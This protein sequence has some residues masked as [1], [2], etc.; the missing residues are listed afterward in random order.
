MVYFGSKSTLNYL[1]YSASKGQY[2][3]QDCQILKRSACRWT[4]NANHR[5][6]FK[7]LLYTLPILLS[8]MSN[9]MQQP[10]LPKLFENLTDN[11][12]P[13][14]NVARTLSDI[15]NVS[16]ES[17]YRRL[18]GETSFDLRELL[19]LRKEFGISIDGLID[20]DEIISIR[21]RSLF[22]EQN[23]IDSYLTDL[24][25]EF[26]SLSRQ[27]PHL[28][29]VAADIP[30]F[31][32]L[33]YESLSSFKLFYWQ[34]SILGKK[35][36]HS[37]T[38]GKDWISLSNSDICKS[39]AKKYADCP[40]VEIWNEQTVNGTLKQV[41]YYSD[42]GFFADEDALYAVYNDI[43]R[44]ILDISID[45]RIGYKHAN[46]GR[47]T[48]SSYALWNCELVIDNNTVFIQNNR[49]QILAIGFNSFN[50]FK[51]SHPAMIKE[52]QGWL[53]SMLSRS[54]L[55]S[56][57]ADKHRIHFIKQMLDRIEASAS[58]RLSFWRLEELRKEINQ[59]DVV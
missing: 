40:S 30:I 44:L 41:E 4:I 9:Y 5:K 59:K 35:E 49:E 54:V 17:A 10:W 23:S 22:G 3:Y 39:I 11:M 47:I 51:C 46:N 12:P 26:S 29:C 48:N 55:L 31:R 20:N 27:D 14:S 56:G 58:S 6:A 28:H 21:M 37:R 25:D 36:L 33:A 34:K 53:N 52:Y 45:S 19:I 13:G 18:R 16:P 50:S 8:S 42:C 15:L 57:Q 43:V 7:C 24:R 32:L 2:V 1:L 38:F